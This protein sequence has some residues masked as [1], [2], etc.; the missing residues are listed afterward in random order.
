MV[1]DLTIQVLIKKVEELAK[2]IDRS[3][4]ENKILCHENALLKAKNAVLKTEIEEL[5]ARLDSNSHNS[6]KPPSSDGYNKKPAFFK[7][8]NGKQGGQKGHKGRTLQ[9][10]EKPDK[11]VKCNPE[12][13]NCGHE[14]TKDELVLSETRQVFD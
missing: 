8:K 10:V 7:E 1:K 3:E 12:K 2:R 14:F 6:S 5:K 13:C 11:I 9:Q 4:K